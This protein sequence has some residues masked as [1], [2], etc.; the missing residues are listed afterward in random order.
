MPDQVPI[1]SHVA[2]PIIEIDGL[3]FRD[4]DGDGELTPY[5]DWRLSPPAERP[6]TWSRA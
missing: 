3:R 5:E 2:P 1:S 6:R 4:L